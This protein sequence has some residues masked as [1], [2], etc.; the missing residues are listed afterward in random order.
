[1]TQYLTQS[2]ID[3]RGFGLAPQGNSKL[4]FDHVECRFDVRPLV[5][6]LHEAF[7]IEVIKV[8]HLLPDRRVTIPTV[9][10]SAVCFE[11]KTNGAKPEG[12]ALQ[13]HAVVFN[14]MSHVGTHAQQ[15]SLWTAF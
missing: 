10:T 1:M 4:R 12:I 11:R 9:I 8:I 13:H 2:L 14:S 7:G 3:L 5:I 15:S 6:A